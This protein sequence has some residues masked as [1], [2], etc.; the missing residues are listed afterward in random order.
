MD[1]Y[2]HKGVEQDPQFVAELTQKIEDI[3]RA[4]ENHFKNEGYEWGYNK[5]WREEA[6][7][8]K[9]QIPGLAGYDEKSI[10]YKRFPGEQSSWIDKLFN[11]NNIDKDLKDEIDRN[12]RERMR[13]L[14]FVKYGAEKNEVTEKLKL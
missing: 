13:Q 4:T 2:Y 10:P 1:K 6:L 11:T 12:A 7:K 3:K 5:I 8:F 9:D 14:G